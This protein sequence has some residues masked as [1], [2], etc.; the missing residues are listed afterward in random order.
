MIVDKMIRVNHRRITLAARNAKTLWTDAVQRIRRFR[1][2]KLVLNVIFM[3]HANRFMIDGRNQ[4]IDT[5]S[6]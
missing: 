5:M 2:L 4:S 1:N 6:N 3:G